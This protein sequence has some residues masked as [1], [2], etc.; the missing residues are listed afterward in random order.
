MLQTLTLE[1]ADRRRLDI[2]ADDEQ[3]LIDSLKVLREKNMIQ[4]M[5]E[6]WVQS[7]RTRR[8]VN[9]FLTYKQAG[10]VN[11]DI[12]KL[13]EGGERDELGIKAESKNHEENPGVEDRTAEMYDGKE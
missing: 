5:P 2:Q 3:R 13:G 10:I 12:L 8:R 1:L 11:G 6:T 4:E 7:L 9:I